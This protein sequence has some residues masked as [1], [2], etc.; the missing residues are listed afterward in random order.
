M[1]VDPN[2]PKAVRTVPSE[3]EAAA[4][5]TALANHGIE[6]STT[7]D[8]TSGFRAEAPGW[9]KVV[10][11]YRDLKQAD[12]ILAQLEANPDTIDWSKID[13]GTTDEES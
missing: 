6:A 7:G 12:Q 10:V 13:V 5:I 4:I 1:N 8:Y 9:V 3:L 11:K 2:S